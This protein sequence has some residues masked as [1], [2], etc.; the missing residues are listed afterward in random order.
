MPDP[1][2]SS[3]WPTPELEPDVIRVGSGP[4]RRGGPLWSLGTGPGG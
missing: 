1:T 2:L 4:C 3:D